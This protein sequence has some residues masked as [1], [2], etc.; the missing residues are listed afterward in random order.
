[1]KKLFLLFAML[2]TLFSAGA[3]DWYLEGNGNG[4][5]Q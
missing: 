4:W 3:T 2:C 1:M 5:G